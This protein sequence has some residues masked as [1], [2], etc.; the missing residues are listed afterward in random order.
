[1]SQECNSSFCQ[2]RDR[3]IGKGEYRISGVSVISEDSKSTVRL[4]SFITE[5]GIPLKRDVI[6]IDYKIDPLPRYEEK[7]EKVSTPLR[8]PAQTP[9]LRRKS[10]PL[11]HN[12]RN[13]K[14]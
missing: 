9:V 10:I 1:M 2:L 3:L 8:K 6:D 5:K 7:E 12:F 13:N 11:P 4:Q 14:N